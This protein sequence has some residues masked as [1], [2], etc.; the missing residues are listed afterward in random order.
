M[1]TGKVKKAPAALV[2]KLIVWLA[3]LGILTACGNN[4]DPDPVYE[5]PDIVNREAIEDVF[6]DHLSLDNLFNYE[7]QNIPNYINEDNTR[8]NDIQNE[9]ATLGRVLFYDKNLS[10]DNTVS[11]SSCHQQ[12]FAFGDPEQL[13]QGV[14]GVT[15]RHSM[16]LINARFADEERFF[17]DERAEDL[18]EQSTMPIQD[19]FEMGF[20]GTNGDSDMN[21]LITK[22]GGLEY[23]VELFELAYG[24]DEI[25]ENRMQLA[26]AQFIRSIQSFDS[27]YDIGRAQVN[28]RDN[29]FPNYSQVENQGKD[30]FFGRARCDRCH[31]GDEFDIDDDSD[32]NGVT[33]VANDPDAIDVD[34]T[35][36]P[37]LR[38]VFNSLGELNG[39]LMHN[40]EF[41]TMEEVIAHYNDIEIDPDNNNLDNRLR[42]GQDGEELNLDQNDVERLV[43][44]LKTLSGRNVYTD[45]KWSD[46]F[47]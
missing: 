29:T 40:G 34:V 46:P 43:A 38:D 42:E 44:F 22:L 21:D 6:G 25:T 13:S 20:S 19:H 37:T 41:E 18:E 27:D 36:A 23:M 1:K 3:I 16:R 28:D 32:N 15:G 31:Q 39:P 11:C 45:E 35:R 7:N 17:W 9:V 5:I 2:L 24:D 26:L 10:S 30:I 8:G 14:N 47:N 33:G 12:A 4:S